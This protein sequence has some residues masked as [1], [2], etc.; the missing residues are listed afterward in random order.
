MLVVIGAVATVLQLLLSPALTFGDAAPGFVVAAAVAVVALL[1]DE[2]HYVFAFVMGLIAD[3]LAQAPLGA[4][5]FSLLVCAFA[6]SMLVEAVGNDNLFM[7]FVVLFAGTLLVEALFSVFLAAFGIL[8][9][10]AAL[11][12]VAFPCA[13]YD[14]ILAILFFAAFSRFTRTR[15]NGAVP[16][17]NVRF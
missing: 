2:R 14:A 15:V 7:T 5:S 9:F 13:L 16:M 6:L 4:T 3:L 1:P 11:V 8:G 17:S 12:H 10:G